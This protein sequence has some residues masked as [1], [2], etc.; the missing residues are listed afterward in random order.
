VNVV[1]AGSIEPHHPAPFRSPPPDSSRQKLVS[2][3]LD[4]LNDFFAG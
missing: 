4:D 1:E 2:G 3:V